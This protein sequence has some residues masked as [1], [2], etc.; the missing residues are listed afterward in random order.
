[1]T[2]MTL[3][4]NRNNMSLLAS[5]GTLNMPPAKDGRDDMIFESFAKY[6]MQS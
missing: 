4:L 2:I 3:P 6:T 1:M 5:V